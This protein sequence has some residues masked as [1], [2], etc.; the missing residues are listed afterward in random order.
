MQYSQNE[1]RRLIEKTELEHGSVSYYEVEINSSKLRSTWN[2]FKP[3]SNKVPLIKADGIEGF[4]VT[5]SND[6]YHHAS[7]LSKDSLTKEPIYLGE[8]TP[9]QD[10]RNE[11]ALERER[12]A[13][14]RKSR[15]I[16][17]EEREKERH[18]SLRAK[19]EEIN[20]FLGSVYD[21]E[22]EMAVLQ[23][24]RPGSSTIR[25]WSIPIE[26]NRIMRS[27]RN[28]EQ[29]DGNLQRIE[30][31]QATPGKSTRENVERL[32]DTLTRHETIARYGYTIE[33]ERLPDDRLSISLETGSGKRIARAIIEPRTEALDVGEN[34]HA[35]IEFFDDADISSY[36]FGR[37]ADWDSFVLES[38]I[39]NEIASK[40]YLTKESSLDASVIIDQE[41]LP[42][43]DYDELCSESLRTKLLEMPEEARAIQAWMESKAPA[44]KHANPEVNNSLSI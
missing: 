37:E 20:S 42:V 35:E 31:I 16:A 19:M 23:S 38:F 40:A 26:Y 22:S 10:K 11:E 18:D 9:L 7:L 30:G 4:L 34:D 17:E 8:K 12:L 6:D 43:A 1:V 25:A 41:G 36:E 13:E 29:A 15:K 21:I 2:E 5:D 24:G 28:I 3:V 32:T 27:I 33:S 39:T 14:E 44:M